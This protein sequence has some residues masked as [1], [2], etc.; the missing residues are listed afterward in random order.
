MRRVDAKK[1][2]NRL[3]REEAS[4][5]AL[6]QMAGEET[7]EWRRTNEEKRKEVKARR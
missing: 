7:H 2:K 1:E 6:V 3:E 4:L 5:S